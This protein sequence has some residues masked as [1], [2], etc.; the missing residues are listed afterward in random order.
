MSIKATRD[1]YGEWLVETGKTNRDIV[2]VDADLAE[3]TKTIMFGKAYPDRFFDVGAAEQNLIDVAAGLAIGGKRVFASSFAYFLTG[4]AWDQIRN[5]VAHD[6]LNVCLVASHGGLSAAADGASHLALQD[7][8]LMRVIPNMRVV[9]P[10]DA[11]ETKSALDTALKE[12]G[13][14]YMRL[15]RDKEP[16]LQK[17]YKFKLGRAEIMRDGEDVTLAAF[18]PMVDASLKAATILKDMMIDARVLNIHTVKPLDGDALEA[19]AKATGAILTIEDHSVY[20]GLGGA[21]A[22]SLSENYPVLITR[23]GIPDVYA[24]SS[25][26]VDSYLKEF[27]LTPDAIAARTEQIVENRK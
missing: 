7:V 22:E 20:G 15:R 24:G 6:N 27:G 16:I 8:S 4:R 25:R 12:G 5:I 14:F 19:A 3:S 13:P 2:V 21:V 9:V 11:E 17:S 10:V 1:A 18:G 26:N 23:L